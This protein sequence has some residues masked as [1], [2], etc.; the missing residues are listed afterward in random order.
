MYMESL[1]DDGDEDGMPLISSLLK[2]GSKLDRYQ[3]LLIP[4]TVWSGVQQAFLISVFSSKIIF[5]L[6]YFLA[7]TLNTIN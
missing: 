2:T 4:L 5:T 7:L 3:A 6:G 1:D